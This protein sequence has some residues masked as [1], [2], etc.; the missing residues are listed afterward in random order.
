MK[1]DE[2]NVEQ[3]EARQAELNAADTEGVATEELE[4]RADE[5]EAIRAELEARRQKAA[6]EEATRQKIAMGNDPV[7][8]EFKEDKKMEETRFAINSPE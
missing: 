3:L 6:A 2:M 1:F 7:I 8:K 5:L 4:A